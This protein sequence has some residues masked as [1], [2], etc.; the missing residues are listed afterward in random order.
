MARKKVQP[1]TG[2]NVDNDINLSELTKTLYTIRFGWFRWGRKAQV[3]YANRLKHACYKV[4][5]ECND[6]ERAWR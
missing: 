5:A 4:A 3:A 1:G 6:F 2:R